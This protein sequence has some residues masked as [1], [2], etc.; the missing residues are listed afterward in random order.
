MIVGDANLCEV[1]TFLKVGTTA[2][3]LAMIEDGF[4][5]KDL[6]IANPVPSM[7][8]VSHDVTCRATVD[9]ADLGACTAIE[10]QWEFLRLARKYA[11]ET[12]L[13]AC[14]GDEIGAQVLDR[15][16]QTLAALERDPFELDGQLDW[17]TKWNLLRAYVDRDG[18]GWDDPKLELLAVQYHDV[19]PGRSLYERLVRAGKVERLVDEA[20]V[21][22]GDGRTAAHD[23]GV[24]PGPLPRQVGRLRGRRQLGQPRPRRRLRPAAKNPDDGAHAW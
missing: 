1:A 6:S 2:I 23:P 9:V 13:E 11:D 5:D 7:R 10:L 15:W 8:T 3:V 19:R 14:G 12:G 16:E 17:V 24:L 4:I 21:L 20:D 22:R 18:L